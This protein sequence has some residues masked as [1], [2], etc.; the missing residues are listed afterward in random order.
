MEDT[1]GRALLHRCRDH[2]DWG[3]MFSA[4]LGQMVRRE[5]RWSVFI[6]PQ[7]KPPLPAADQ[8]KAL[9]SVWNHI[10]SRHHPLLELEQMGLI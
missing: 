6:K 4:F 7:R 5:T 3:A 9:L 8:L 10:I 2:R 1:D